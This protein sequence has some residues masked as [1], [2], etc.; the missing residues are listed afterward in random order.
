MVRQKPARSPLLSADSRFAAAFVLAVAFFRAGRGAALSSEPDERGDDGGRGGDGR[1]HRGAAA[2]DASASDRFSSRGLF[3][4]AHEYDA[5]AID[6]ISMFGSPLGG[7]SRATAGRL[8]SI[9]LRLPLVSL[10]SPPD[11]PAYLRVRDE[12][13]RLFACRVYHQDELEPSSW[14]DGLF[15]APRLARPASAEKSEDEG[16][17]ASASTAASAVSS[18]AGESGSDQAGIAGGGESVDAPA[19]SGV[20]FRDRRRPGDSGGPEATKD[21][22]GTAQAAVVGADG[23]IVPASP[24]DGNPIP[25]TAAEATTTAAGTDGAVGRDSDSL[26]SPGRGL[27][28][29]LTEEEVEDRLGAFEGLCAH[30]HLGYWSTEWSVSLSLSL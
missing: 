4:P 8:A 27:A 15:D 7:F 2:S 23:T 9:P 6:P 13:G 5:L 17:G 10:E 25:L 1:W 18:A 28:A 26:A 22:A 3:P 29:S 21:D 30:I 16:A 12:S 20:T 11:D 14:S 24:A 19:A